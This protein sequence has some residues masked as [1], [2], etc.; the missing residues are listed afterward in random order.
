MLVVIVTRIATAIVA[1]R[2]GQYVGTKR[3]SADL[4]RT[5]IGDE[6][7]DLVEQVY[8]ACKERWQYRVPRRKGD[9]EQLHT[10]CQRAL[11]FEN[12][13]YTLYRSYLLEELYASQRE[14]QLRAVERLGQIIYPGEEIDKALTLLMEDAD[15]EVRQA[16]AQTKQ[17]RAS[18]QA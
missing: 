18:A 13:F 2:A 7:I 1:L 11:G 17:Q 10:L 16:M 15:A 9:Q 14:D 6:W 3:D 4:Y 12:H 5:H 8:Q